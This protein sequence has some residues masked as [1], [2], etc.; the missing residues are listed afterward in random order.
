MPV[1]LGKNPT[2]T[3]SPNP[4]FP[5]ALTLV[6]GGFFGGSSVAPSPPTKA[7]GTMLFII[8]CIT[9]P[10]RLSTRA[11][12]LSRELPYR[13]LRLLLTPSPPHPSPP[14]CH[15]G[16]VSIPRTG[17]F[18]S[19]KSL[20]ETGGGYNFEFR[21]GTIATCETAPEQRIGTRG[22]GVESSWRHHCRP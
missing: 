13:F 15:F 17:I 4:V 11:R 18:V 7:V 22:G 9:P 19:R 14:R 1:G 6:R 2:H 20:L 16:A 12:Q 10:P 5:T 3:H 21:L 8:S